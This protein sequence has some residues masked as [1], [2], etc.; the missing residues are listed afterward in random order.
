MLIRTK[1]NIPPIRTRLLARDRLVQWLQDG[2]ERRLSLISAPAGFGKTSLVC[3]WIEQHKLRAAWYSLDENDNDPSLFFR[4]LL[5]ALQSQDKSLK[6]AFKPLLHGQKMPQGRDVM[7]Q[8]IHHLENLP[9]KIFVV[10]DD[11]HVIQSK[12]IHEA[13][14]DLLQNIPPQMHII[15]TTRHDVPFPVARLRAKGEMVEIRAADL[16][17][18]DEESERFFHE[19][20]HLDLP[21]TEVDRLCEKTEGWIIGMRMAGL[22]LQEGEDRDTPAAGFTGSDR[23]VLDYLTEEVLGRQPDEIQTFLV[24][25][26]ILR[27]LNPDLCLEVAG[28]KNASALMDQLQ[29]KDLF[30]VPLDREGRW[31]RYHHLFSESLQRRLEHSEP[32][33][34]EDLHRKAAVWYAKNGY[35]EEAFQH[36]FESRDLEFAADLLEDHLF[37]YLIEY[38]F[39]AARRWLERMPEEIARERY[40]LM[41]YRA[42][43]VFLQE[44]NEPLDVLLKD[45]EQSPARKMKGYGDSKRSNA[46]DLLQA[47]RIG[48][49]FFKD[50]SDET[51]P[52]AEEALASMSPG[53][54]L[55]RGFVQLILAL[56]NVE[57][58]DIQ[59][60][61][62]AGRSALK[63]L[64]SSRSPYFA[65]HALALEAEGALLQGRL[66]NAERILTE[67]LDSVRRDGLPMKAGIVEFHGRLAEISY[68][69]NELD[70]ALELSEQ[71]IEYARPASDMGPLLQGM[72][73]QAF[74]R[75]IGGRTNQ[76][77]EL[78]EEALALA[79]GTRS[80]LRMAHTEIGSLQLAM[81]Q[82]DYDTLSTWAAARKLRIDEPFSRVFEDECMVL[83]GLHLTQNRCEEAAGLLTE[84]RPRSEKRQRFDSVLKIDIAHACALQA[85]GEEEE[86]LSILKKAV[87]FARPEGYVRPFVDHAPHLYDPLR[88]LMGREEGPLRRYAKTLLKAC[89]IPRPGSSTKARVQVNDVETLTPREVEILRMIT[90]GMTNKEIAEKTFVSINTIKTHIRHIFGKLGVTDRDE[91]IRKSGELEGF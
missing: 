7:A 85:L 56:A 61:V 66:R 67:A 26:S 68:R 64:G 34:A 78:M 27:R 81:L 57:K 18:T 23:F 6:A 29:R 28:M 49:L 16:R 60:A 2:T 51:I 48:A 13:M 14:H 87:V 47:L 30:L 82:A 33:S 24:R 38:E 31:Y 77:R 4:Y 3:Q 59:P 20:M 76:A 9:A 53:R 86:A 21:S 5:T 8:V 54:A 39:A 58:G 55:T 25:T 45:L 75:E 11:Y 35:P 50:L 65:V 43:V 89:S 1:L 70:K 84:L 83:A 40:L 42:W 19:V 74:I 22:S 17:F 69:R 12:A 44:E 73:L 62:E 10:L 52:A 79:R 71:C 15:I 37:S 91:A 88:E 90:A 63:D 41:L 46:D 32:G 80:R 72:C 36:A